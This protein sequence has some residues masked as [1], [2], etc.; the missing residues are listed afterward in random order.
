[1]GIRKR[2][3][4]EGR[5][6]GRREGAREGRTVM[7]TMASRVRSSSSSSRSR[8]PPPPNFLTLEE[9]GASILR[10][11]KLGLSG[12][13]EKGREGES[14]RERDKERGRQREREKEIINGSR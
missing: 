14:E 2:Q 9:A 8:L 10:W 6:E 12:L 5:N 4:G 3:G 1:M 13:G 7:P 11:A